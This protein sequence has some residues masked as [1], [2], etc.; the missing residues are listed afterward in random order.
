MKLGGIVS[1]T[2]QLSSS[3]S[4]H[5][6]SIHS[7]YISG[8]MSDDSESDFQP[9]ASTSQL[10]VHS[11]TPSVSTSSSTHPTA[12]TSLPTH[13]PT[14]T[15]SSSSS[16]I[17]GP[18][19]PNRTK[20]PARRASEASNSAPTPSA[21]PTAGPSAARPARARK[22][23]VKVAPS[24]LPSKLKLNFSKKAGI[25]GYNS[26][27]GE[28]DRELDSDDEEIEFEE[29]FIL[30]LPEGAPAQDL[31][32]L[33]GKKGKNKEKALEG[34]W[35]KFK[36]SRRAAFHLSNQLYAAKLVDLPSIIE[37]QKTLDGKQMFK[38]A[39]ISQ[40]LVVTHPIKDES[41]VIQDGLS[42]GSGKM[43]LDDYIWPH[44]I[45]PP[46]RHVRKR[47]YRKRISR[48]TIEIVEEE[49][50]KLLDEDSRAE[51]TSYEILEDI[52]PDLSD[53]ELLTPAATPSTNLL[54]GGSEYAGSEM[55]DGMTPMN[56]DGDGGE[57][58][59]DLAA[60]LTRG[61]KE[62]DDDEE[63][64]EKD[65]DE[66][67]DDDDDD[68]PEEDEEDEEEGSD[69]DSED[70]EAV[71]LAQRQKLLNEEIRDLEAAVIK[72]KG[73]IERSGNVIIKKRFED[74]LR[75]LQADLDVKIAA[76]AQNVQEK[77]KRKRE[78]EE[79]KEREK[80][81]REAALRESN[82]VPS[83]VSSAA[84][85]GGDTNNG[86]SASTVSS[87]TTT[88]T[89]GGNHNLV[90]STNT[91]DNDT[92]GSSPGK[93]SYSPLP[94][95]PSNL[96]PLTQGSSPSSS[97]M[98]SLPVPPSLAPGSNAPSSSL[99]SFAS[100][101]QMAQQKTTYIPSSL[102]TSALPDD[103]TGLENQGD[104][105]RMDGDVQMTDLE[106]LMAAGLDASS[107]TDG[108]G[109]RDRDVRDGDIGR[110]AEGEDEDEE[111]EEEDLFGG[112]DESA[113]E[114]DMDVV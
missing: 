84:T 28:Y 106:A 47:R 62:L 56:Q 29:Q 101:G 3:S 64:E 27:L 53:S 88:T 20:P 72:K 91:N 97:S 31:R 68:E 36:D 82:P 19:P 10:P 67:D 9:V 15:V 104:P 46:L 74:A 73:E 86:N 114:D 100:N 6:P 111:D 98:S 80:A 89:T 43:N 92:G 58:G 32:A 60:E 7:S 93:F 11:S 113:G 55:G 77:E 34:I 81:F 66:D 42:S 61:L 96:G 102:G 95:T 71:Q 44:G 16:A 59:F 109:D 76:R 112:S 38:A 50:E 23:T 12:F 40:M 75:K 13:T 41:E 5:Q 37:S 21:D 87:Y 51:K 83:A 8:Q 105:G 78:E 49:V 99:S 52:D 94:P 54:V 103:R 22:P 26:F 25:G 63:D 35:F 18:P 33:L 17:P 2:S 70:E 24:V 107:S 65:D 45:T 90:P 108:D 85:A 30:R 1:V 4:S 57:D 69:A 48:R 110:D 39:D 79:E 14:P